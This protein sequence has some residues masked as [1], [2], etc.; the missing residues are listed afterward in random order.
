MSTFEFFEKHAVRSI[1]ETS[2]I[3][4]LSHSLGN[5]LF[6]LLYVFVIPLLEGMM[7]NC[8]KWSVISVTKLPLQTP[9]TGLL[10]KMS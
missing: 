7:Q 4:L 8:E 1:S 9:G 3:N 10:M 6:F 5:R 2:F